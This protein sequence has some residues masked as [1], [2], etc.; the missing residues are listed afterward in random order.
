MERW[1]EECVE[2]G[3]TDNSHDI[4]LKGKELN[5]AVERR[6]CS[7]WWSGALRHC[8]QVTCCIV[9]FLSVGGRPDDLDGVHVV[10]DVRVLP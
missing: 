3:S 6:T 1:G 4:Q 9:P 8:L 10:H 5:C 2:T 7:E